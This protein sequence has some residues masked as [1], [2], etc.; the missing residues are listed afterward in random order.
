MTHSSDEKWYLGIDLGTGSCKC[1]IVDRSGTPLGFGVG[2]YVEKRLISRWKEQN[3]ESLIEGMIQ[4]IQAAIRDADVPTQDCAGLSLGGALHSI[5]AI[6]ENSRPLTGV[7]TWADERATPQAQ[8]LRNIQDN[9]SLY[10]QTGCPIHG[11]YPLYKVIWL[12]ENHP[13]LFKKAARFIS[14]KEYI[15]ACLTGKYIVDYSLASG[16]GLLNVNKLNWHSPSLELAGIEPDR[17]SQL[18]SPYEVI[19]GLD[20]QM[21]TKIGI[22]IRTPFV[23]G[24]SDAVN[25]NLGAGAVDSTQAACM[26]GTSGA[27]RIISKQPILD[28]QARSWCYCIDQ[29]HWLVGGAI[30]NGGL[31]LAWLRDTLNRVISSSEAHDQLA[32]DDLTNL[33]EEVGIGADGVI[34]LPFL[35]GERSPNWNMNA[36]GIF[37]GLQLHHDLRHL[38]RAILEGVAFRM[39]SIRDVLNDLNIH[40][41]QIHTSG[42]INR[43]SLWLRILSSVLD[44]ELLV[45]TW[46]ETPSLGAAFWVLLGTKVLDS[47]SDAGNLVHI[48]GSYQ[49][50][51]EDVETYNQLYDIYSR[52]YEAV[53]P[54]YD[55]IAE[56]QMTNNF[57]E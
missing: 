36:R 13:D 27:F 9:N 19:D 47:F 26:V 50:K 54:L 25:S 44:M 45:P 30:N 4:A 2:E 15:T 22:P 32:F 20:H 23:L 16:T 56:F 46:A 28:S 55:D 38:A 41:N 29:S 24:S 18:S 10:E 37:F 31:V 43:S 1:V 6:D 48:S 8:Q 7:I 33:A 21:A 40:L 57:A 17:L 49:P 42:G 34:C 51:L 14:A 39:R 5:M 12:R 11:M 3:P 35:T 52:I 53:L